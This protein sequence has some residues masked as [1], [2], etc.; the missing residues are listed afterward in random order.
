MISQSSISNVMFSCAVFSGTRVHGQRLD[1][2]CHHGDGWE[3][4]REQNHSPSL[5]HQYRQGVP[6]AAIGKGVCQIQAGQ[7][8][9]GKPQ[10]ESAVTIYSDLNQKIIKYFRSIRKCNDEDC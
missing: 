9:T 1:Q 7:L 10:V 5:R 6:S 2:I 3:R 4:G 8:I